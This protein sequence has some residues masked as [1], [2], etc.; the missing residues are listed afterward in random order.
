MTARIESVPARDRALREAA[1]TARDPRSA[2]EL[3]ESLIHPW[4][5]RPHES[6]VC[7]SNPRRG[8]RVM[9]V[10]V[11]GR[12]REQGVEAARVILGG[13]AA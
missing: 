11:T 6:C 1:E 7:Q 2:A 12:E 4:C 5:G 13:R 10:S 3:V 8:G 9:P